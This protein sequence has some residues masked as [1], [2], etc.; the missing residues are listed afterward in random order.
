MQG[1]SSAAV[2]S[3]KIDF[4]S[5]AS[6]ARPEQMHG[7][8]DLSPSPRPL[9]EALPVSIY[10]FIIYIYIYGEKGVIIHTFRRRVIYRAA[11]A[12]LLVNDKFGGSWR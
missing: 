9:P 11:D 1:G 10:L 8:S 6:A 12:L 7:V 5:E 3:V 4:A 2:S